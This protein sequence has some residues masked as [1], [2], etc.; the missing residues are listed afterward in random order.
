MASLPTGDHRVK[1]QEDQWAD[2]HTPNSRL[3]FRFSAVTFNTHRIH[4][5]QPYATAHEG[6]PAL[7]VQGPL[8]ALLVAESIRRTCEK[9]LVRFEFRAIAPL[10]VDSTFTIVG[11][12]S[13]EISAEVFRNDGV[14]AM[15]V[16]AELDS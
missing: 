11:S 13:A 1:L 9:D 8:T 15:E 2:R 6:Y 7:V 14:K 4:F 10:F 3:L 5:D 12:P 16:V